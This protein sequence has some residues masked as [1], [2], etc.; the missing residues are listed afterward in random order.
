MDPAGNVAAVS[1]Y[2]EGCNLKLA[3][4][5]LEKLFE[6]LRQRKTFLRAYG[7]KRLADRYK[8]SEATVKR[9]QRKLEESEATTTA[10]AAK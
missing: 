9:A 6:D 10:R 1:V 5:S 4:D 2:F 7:I 8:V 3:Q